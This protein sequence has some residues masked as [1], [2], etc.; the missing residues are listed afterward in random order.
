MWRLLATIVL[1]LALMGLTTANRA[2]ACLA[3]FGAET[4]LSFVK[5]IEERN[6]ETVS[7]LYQ[8][9]ACAWLGAGFDAE[10]L[11]EGE[12]WIK[13]RLSAPGRDSLDV[14]TTP[15]GVKE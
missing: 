7:R 4:F 5:A 14:F 10:L 6:G 15:D 8:S 2:P 12:G 3:E 1:A 13:V 9:G 11:E